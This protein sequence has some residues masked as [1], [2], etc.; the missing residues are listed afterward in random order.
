MES[1]GE[2]GDGEEGNGEEDLVRSFV[3]VV[4]LRN[5]SELFCWPT[6]TH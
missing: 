2:E 4:V 3:P 1:N 6:H 5:L